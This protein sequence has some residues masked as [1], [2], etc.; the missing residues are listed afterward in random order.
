MYYTRTAVAAAAA[1]LLLAAGCTPTSAP[2]AAA[3]SA[4]AITSPSPLPSVPMPADAEELI[5]LTQ[6]ALAAASSMTVRGGG[7]SEGDTTT[8]D[9]TGA[10]DD[11][12]YHLLMGQGEASVEIIVVEAELYLKANQEFFTAIGAEVE[13]EE[14]AGRWVT[15][16]SE[17]TAGLSEMSPSSLVDM[18]VEA[19]AVDNVDPDVTRDNIEGRDVFVLTNAEGPESGQA[20]IAADGTWLP[21]RFTGSENSSFTFSGWNE[22]VTVQAPPADQVVSIE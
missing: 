21:V 13:G 3:P 6:T 16:D 2:D 1:G 17:L 9:L 19:L 20:S 15:G 8:I 22:P 12:A 5:G 10:L 18:F 4:P 11:S 7:G 14:Y